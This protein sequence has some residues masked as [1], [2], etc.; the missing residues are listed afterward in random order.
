MGQIMYLES[1]GAT[2]CCLAYTTLHREG[3]KKKSFSVS[4]SVSRVLQ[5]VAQ[6]LIK[7]GFGLMGLLL[8][9]IQKS[10]AGFNEY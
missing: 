9:R 1:L 5:V 8:P 4:Q 7:P 2:K 6:Q 3:F 10:V